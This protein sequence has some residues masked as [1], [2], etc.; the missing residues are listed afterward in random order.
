VRVAVLD[1]GMGNLRSV[2]KALEAAG[3]DV[4]VTSSSAEVDRSDALCVPGQGIFGRCMAN[5]AAAEQDDLIRGWIDDQRPYLGI[6][7]GMQILFDSS[8][9]QRGGASSTGLSIFPGVVRRLRGDVRI[10][11]MGWNEVNDEHYYFD[12]SYAVR[13]R[14]DSLVSGWCWHGERF[15]ASIRSGSVTAVQ[16]HPEKSATAGLTLLSDWTAA[17]EEAAV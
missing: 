2:A 10:P 8:E 13:P 1:Y 7:L 9:E 4:V 11:H 5:L 3:A 12:H 15:A 17:L 16:F 14:D 6:C